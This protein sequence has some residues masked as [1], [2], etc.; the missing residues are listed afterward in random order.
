MPG[1]VNQRFETESLPKVQRTDPLGRI[2]L[3]SRHAEHVDTKFAHKRRYLPCGL[4][5]IRV[6]GYLS[7]ARKKIPL[8][9]WLLASLPPPVKMISPGWAPSS[10]AT[11]PRAASTASRAGRPAQWALEGLPK[12]PDRKGRIDSATS[13]ASGVLAL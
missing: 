5:R 2:Q 3:M 13:G 9:A 11:S 12:W 8:I 1:T 10:A 4:R 7:L 6:K